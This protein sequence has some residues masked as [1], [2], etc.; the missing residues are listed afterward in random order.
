MI[1]MD[2]SGSIL[3]LEIQMILKLSG[4]SLLIDSEFLNQHLAIKCT[5]FPQGN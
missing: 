4:L 3:F 1:Q 5:M 2:H